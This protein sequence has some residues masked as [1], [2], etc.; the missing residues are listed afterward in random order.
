MHEGAVRMDHVL[1]PITPVGKPRMTRRDKWMVRPCV[2][3]YRNYLDVLKLHAI[4][5]QKSSSLF[6]RFEIPMPNSWSKKKKKEM[7]Q[8]P[9]QQKPD[10][11][12]LVKAVLDSLF[13]DD[14]HVFYINAFK[15]W[16][17]VGSV[18]LSNIDALPFLPDPSVVPPR[19]S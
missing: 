15:T 12:N 4:H 17:H 7:H 3:K 11:D 8:K 19:S 13:H 9:H 14:S 18:F 10:I 2:K 16:S 6:I 5:F 1:I